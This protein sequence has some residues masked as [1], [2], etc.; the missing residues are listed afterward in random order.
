MIFFKEIFAVFTLSAGVVETG[1][2]TIITDHINQDT[3]WT[4][5]NSPYRV[6]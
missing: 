3:F 5:A 4:Q 6:Q 2:E 1:A